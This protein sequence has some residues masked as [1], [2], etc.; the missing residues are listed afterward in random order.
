MGLPSEEGQKLECFKWTTHYI[1][2]R[3]L[4]KSSKP[5]MKKSHSSNL[6]HL[7]SLYVSYMMCTMQACTLHSHR[8]NWAEFSALDVGVLCFSMQL[9]SQEKNY[10]I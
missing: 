5:V 7:G 9:H 6:Y 4:R 2:L 10:Q 1:F 3:L 8:T